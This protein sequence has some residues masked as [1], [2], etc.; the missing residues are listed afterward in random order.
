M[1]TVEQIINGIIKREGGYVF[2]PNDRGGPTKFGVTLETAKK[3]GLDKD[4]DGD[5]DIEDVK[6]L[7]KEDAYAVFYEGYHVLPG[8]PKTP[9][10]LH[11]VLTDMCVHHGQGRAIMIMQKCANFVDGINIDVDGGIGKQTLAA[12]EDICGRFPNEFRDG[13]SIERR[14]FMWRIC[15]NDPTQQVFFMTEKRYKGGW[16]KRS[17]E[18]M[19]DDYHWNHELFT[20]R[21]KHWEDIK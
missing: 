7:S 9:Q 19:D 5:V 11:P 4:G 21:T 1:L 3:F 16:P 13:V 17:E 6:L 8:I 10:I 15:E 20:R 2:N 12:V 14:E 18:F